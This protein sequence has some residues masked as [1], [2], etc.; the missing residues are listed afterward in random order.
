VDLHISAPPA[1]C[2]FDTIGKYSWRRGVRRPRGVAHVS[3]LQQRNLDPAKVF[4][5][6]NFPAL[7][8]YYHLPGCQL[9]LPVRPT[10]LLSS[11]YCIINNTIRLKVTMFQL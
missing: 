1:P 10:L 9:I 2:L 11:F 5:H 4:T 7:P 8:F 6:P 3:V